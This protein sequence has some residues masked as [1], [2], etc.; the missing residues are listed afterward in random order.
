MP[1]SYYLNIASLF[2]WTTLTIRALTTK[3]DLLHPAAIFAA[4]Y[5]LTYPAKLF[6]SYYNM[7]MLDSMSVKETTI[8]LSIFLSNLTALLVLCPLLRLPLVSTSSDIFR[9]PSLN[10][11][12]STSIAI[13]LLSVKYGLS[14][15]TA[16]FS[17]AGLQNRITE[18]TTE[19]LGSGLFALLLDLSFLFLCILAA[20]VVSRSYSSLFVVFHTSIISLFSLLISGSK[21]VG[22]VY[23]AVL[24]AYWYYQKRLRGH[25]KVGLI[26]ILIIVPLGLFSVGFFGFIRGAGSYGIEAPFIVQTFNQLRYAFDSPDNLIVLLDRIPNIW[27]GALG[28]RLPTDYLILPFIPRFLFPDKPLVR[29]NQLI[30]QQFFPERFTDHLGEAISPSM[31]G[32]FLLAGGVIYLII[33]STLVGLLLS[34]LYLKSQTK[35]GYFFVLY[36]WTLVNLYSLLR[37]PTGLLGAGI[38]FF[39][40]TGFAYLLLNKLPKRRLF[41]EY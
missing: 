28:L 34:Y 1:L 27:E 36:L 40:V 31:P 30:M 17:I 15:V 25:Y 14:A 24:T 5:T 19:R 21:Y 8:L 32:D 41:R 13:L 4:I 12:L 35:G 26:Q 6:L 11:W 22:L 38:K 29:G 20:R 18:R 2:L 37:S 10:P 23:P 3:R 33:A 7:T 39:I 9:L 16:I